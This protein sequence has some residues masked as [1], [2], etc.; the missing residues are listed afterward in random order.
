MSLSARLTFLVYLADL[1]YRTF[2]FLKQLS[3]LFYRHKKLTFL[4]WESSY[5][6]HT[7]KLALL[8]W[9]SA[10]VWFQIKLLDF[11]RLLL[12]L[13]L[14]PAAQAQV[15]FFFFIYCLQNPTSTCAVVKLKKQTRRNNQRLTA[16]WTHLTFRCQTQCREQSIILHTS[17]G[18]QETPWKL[19]SSTT[20]YFEL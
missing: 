4:N 20:W 18:P 1:F 16:S 12:L 9:E 19:K 5:G 7:M 14:K 15:R 17:L 8:D 6:R 3:L 13:L 2:T 11:A 10:F